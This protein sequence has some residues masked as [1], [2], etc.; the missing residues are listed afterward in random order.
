MTYILGKTTNQLQLNC[1][2]CLKPV[3]VL[4]G[5]IPFCWEHVQ[6]EDRFRRFINAVKENV[7]DLPS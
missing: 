6:W 2:H 7:K 1:R 5:P 4:I 3:E